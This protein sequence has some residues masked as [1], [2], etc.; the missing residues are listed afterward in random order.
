MARKLIEEELADDDDDEEEGGEVN[1]SNKSVPQTSEESQEQAS[2]V[3]QMDVDLPTGRE[4][5]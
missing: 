3:R 2:N 4:K 1:C 5:N